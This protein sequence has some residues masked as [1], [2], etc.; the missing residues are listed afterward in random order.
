MQ[1]VPRYAMIAS[2]EQLIPFAPGHNAVQVPYTQAVTGAGQGCLSVASVLSPK[3]CEVCNLEEYETLRG[4]APFAPN[5][6]PVPATPAPE[7]PEISA[8]APEASMLVESTAEEP[9]G[10]LQGTV[11]FF[12]CSFCVM[13]VHMTVL[14]RAYNF[15]ISFGIRGITII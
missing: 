3:Q 4:G 11:Y 8:P 12:E 9:V 15:S 7:S 10:V 5:D 2:A 13:H 1:T 6:S 14:Q